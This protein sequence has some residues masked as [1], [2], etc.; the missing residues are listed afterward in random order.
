LPSR[1]P[2]DRLVRALR[3][4]RIPAAVSHHA[5][6]FLCNHVFYVALAETRVPCGFVHLPPTSAVS[7]PA[8][9]RAVDA[10]IRSL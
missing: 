1:L 8:Q 2:I 3:R 9:I 10:L 6:T 5:G 4:A 7:L